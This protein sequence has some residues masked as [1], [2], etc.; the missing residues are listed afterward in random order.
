M[1][2]KSYQR[3]KKRV[4]NLKSFYIHLS[5]FILVNSMFILINVLS[6]EESGHWWFFYPLLGWGI[7]IASHGISV[8]SFGILGPD[9]EE[10]KIQEYMEKEKKAK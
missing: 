4:E 10:R 2:D 5:V 3:A 7:G 6:Y 1:E 8:A 9:W